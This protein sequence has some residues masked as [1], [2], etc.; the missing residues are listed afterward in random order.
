[1][2]LDELTREDLIALLEVYA[3]NWLAHDGCW[4]LAAERRY[5]MQPAIELDTASWNCFSPVEAKRIKDAFRLPDDGGLDA[6]E[7]ALG[8]RLY[9]AVNRQE[10]ERVDDRTLRFRMRECRVQQARRRKG[11]PA[12]PCKSVGV[13][14]YT[15]FAE[16]VD[17]R[18]ET[19]CV[20]APPDAVTDSY[21]EWEFRLKP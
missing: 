18:I 12:F 14:E 15:R 10:A 20:H 19:R 1:M 13:V 8:Y 5:G 9:A 11:L 16:T 7:R 6:L 17:P 2:N 21:C 3:K 4:F